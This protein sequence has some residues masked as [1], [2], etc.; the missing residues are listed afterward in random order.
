MKL[1]FIVNSISGGKSKHAAIQT[2]EKVLLAKEISFEIVLTND[3]LSGIEATQKALSGRYSAVVAVG[4]DGTLQALGSV[5][6][7]TATPLGIIPM[8]SGNGLARMLRI[9]FDVTDALDKIIAA[10][11]KTIDVGLANGK[12]FMNVCGVGFDAH[13]SAQFSHSKSRGFFNYARLIMQS[14]F[15]YQKETYQI[16]TSNET[17]TEKAFL[18]S[19][20][21]GN[22]F[23]N[24]AYIAPGAALDDGLLNMTALKKIPVLSIPRL[25]YLLFNQRL[26]E[27]SQVIS[28]ASNRFVLN[29]LNGHNF[30]YH[31]DGEPMPAVNRIEITL[32]SRCLMVIV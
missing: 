7:N 6:I 30:H 12:A 28:L 29:Q 14:L 22:Q 9:P 26:T 32:N 15:G 8:G 31:L 4:G 13:I 1:L 2:I 21:N 16:E 3:A 11:T 10:K 18:V 23:G 17:I 5:L 27:N 19:F 25:I 20:C 24:N